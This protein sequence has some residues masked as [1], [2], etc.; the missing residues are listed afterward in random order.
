MTT[1]KNSDHVMDLKNNE[2]F[3]DFLYNVSNTKLITLRD[4]LNDVVTKE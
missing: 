4:W 1:H 2:F 3:Y